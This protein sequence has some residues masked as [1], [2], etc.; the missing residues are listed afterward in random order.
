[1]RHLKTM[2]IAT[3]VSVAFAM[4]AL[5]DCRIDAS[6]DFTTQMKSV[7]S[8]SA[9]NDLTALRNAAEV[10]KRHDKD[11]ACQTVVKAMTELRTAFAKPNATA[12]AATGEDRVAQK[13]DRSDVAERSGP[14]ELKRLRASKLMGADLIGPNGDEVAEIDD[15]VLNRSGGDYAIVSFGGFLGMGDEQ[16]AVPVRQILV[17]RDGDNVTFKLPMTVDQLKAAPRFKKNSQEWFEDDSWWSS[18]DNYYAGVSAPAA[19]K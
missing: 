5:A 16:A 17:V 9:R 11:E 8:E 19:S 3:A 10:L 13:A 7:K 12:A 15:L 6:S 1:M 2:A 4:P 14:L 18:N